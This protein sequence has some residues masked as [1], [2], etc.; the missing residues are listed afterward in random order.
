MAQ[1]SVLVLHTAG[2]PWPCSDNSLTTSRSMLTLNAKRKRGSRNALNSSCVGLMLKYCPCQPWSI[3]W[4]TW[5]PSASNSA[6]RSGVMPPGGS[7]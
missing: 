2:L 5:N 7:P 4:A 3:P 1:L 6:V